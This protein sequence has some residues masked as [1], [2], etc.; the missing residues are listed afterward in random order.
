MK[1]AVRKTLRA[2]EEVAKGPREWSS[3]GGGGGGGTGS[4]GKGLL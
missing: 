3:G 2:G 4:F 1:K